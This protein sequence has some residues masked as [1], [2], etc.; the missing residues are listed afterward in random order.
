MSGVIGSS[1]RESLEA[2]LEISQEENRVA[3]CDPM[4]LTQIAARRQEVFERIQAAEQDC[5]QEYLGI[6]REVARLDEDTRR[7]V[8][9]HM[10]DVKRE[11]KRAQLAR[12]YRR[13][14]AE[15]AMCIDRKI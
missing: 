4:D 11:L 9:D 6:L 10:A 5:C 14:H 1:V 3:R 15:Q 8:H 13:L 2:L 7:L 12:G